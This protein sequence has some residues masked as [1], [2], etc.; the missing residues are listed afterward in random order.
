MVG[1]SPAVVNWFK[2]YL[3]GCSQSTRIASTLCDPVPITR[4]VPQ[5]ATLSPLL[6]CI[7]FDDSFALQT[8]CLESNV[9]D[10]KV[11]QSF[12]MSDIDSATRKLEDNLC[13][14]MWCCDN[15]VLLINPARPNSFSFEAGGLPFTVTAT[16]F[17]KPLRPADFVTDLGVILDPH[18]TYNDYVLK[19]VSSCFYKLSQVYWVIAS[20]DSKT[21]L[22][23]MSFLP[24]LA[25]LHYF[26]C[27]PHFLA[28]KTSLSPRG[29]FW[30][31][32]WMFAKPMANFVIFLCQRCYFTR[33]TLVVSFQLSPTRWHF[34]LLP[35]VLFSLPAFWR[36]VVLWQQNMPVKPCQIVS[37][38][39]WRECC[40]RGTFYAALQP[41]RGEFRTRRSCEGKSRLPH[42][43]W[44]LNAA[45]F[46]HLVWRCNKKLTYKR[47]PIQV[48]RNNQVPNQTTTCWKLFR[49]LGGYSAVTPVTYGHLGAIKNFMLQKKWKNSL[50]CQILSETKQTENQCWNALET[51]RPHDLS[52][53]KD[54]I[55]SVKTK[56]PP[57]HTPLIFLRCK[58]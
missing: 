8:C 10:S 42:F 33:H 13:N 7:Y 31:T 25:G 40:S 21:L 5:G 37:L 47:E 48:K 16:F 22:L 3:F 26:R 9:D 58:F 2:S 51:H 55:R 15:N 49:T 12:P 54:I 46:C 4:G 57:Q 18:L 11:L 44:V 28:V 56:N 23:I 52:T 19:V 32:I 6:F 30:H 14:A 45:H 39:R 36:C 17:D 20:F 27:I 50:K 38:R 34:F 24:L 53:D 35:N 41:P 1:A 29:P 43:L